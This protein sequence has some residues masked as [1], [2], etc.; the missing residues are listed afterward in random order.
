[1]APL[2]PGRSTVGSLMMY[3]Y[4]LGLAVPGVFLAPGA[5]LPVAGATGASGGGLLP[6]V[7]RARGPFR[8]TMWDMVRRD[9]RIRAEIAAGVRAPRRFLKDGPRGGEA[10]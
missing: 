3:P 8:D 1:M 4:R 9:A 5:L 7:S 10:G 2:D 6:A